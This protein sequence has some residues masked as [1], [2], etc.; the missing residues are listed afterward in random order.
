M[1]EESVDVMRS[2]SMMDPDTVAH[3]YK[4]G[5]ALITAYWKTIWRRG[6][7]KGSRA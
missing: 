3:W 5:N 1:A 2:L 6:A 7:C 4:D